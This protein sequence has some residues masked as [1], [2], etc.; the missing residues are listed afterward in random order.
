MIILPRSESMISEVFI[1]NKM[2]DRKEENNGNSGGQNNAPS[3]PLKIPETCE[4]L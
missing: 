2:K 4:Y 3:S 1:S